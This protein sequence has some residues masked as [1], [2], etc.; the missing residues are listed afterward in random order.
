MEQSTLDNAVEEAASTPNS[1]PSSEIAPEGTPTVIAPQ[2]ELSESLSPASEETPRQEVEGGRAYEI[3]F[4]TRAGDADATETS[5]GRMR[6]MIEAT[7][8]A[9]DNVRTSE[10]RRL[11][12]PIAREIE[13]V[14]TVV[15]TRFAN[16][17]LSELDRFFKLE[18]SVLRHMILRDEI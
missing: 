7:G 18:E 3:I 16:Q 4:I 6:A 10:V 17:N 13:G 15:N 12:Y 9:I 1:D 14:Y 2:P 8:G 5:I 11:A